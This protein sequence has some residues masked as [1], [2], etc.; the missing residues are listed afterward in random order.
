MAT[1]KID[2][3]RKVY[4]RRGIMHLCAGKGLLRAPDDTRA[5]A[6]GE[7]QLLGTDLDEGGIALVG[8][9]VVDGRLELW[10]AWPEGRE[11]GEEGDGLR[12]LYKR[13]GILHFC[14]RGKLYAR[15]EGSAAHHESRVSVVCT[16][17]S[18]AT[19]VLDASR[20]V[21]VWPR[22]L[23]GEKKSEKIA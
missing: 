11:K 10:S 1:K 12:K 2:R 19:V 20:A 14:H 21:E 17:E 7:V 9:V 18:C 6:G 8:E 3:S 16:D 22:W 23:D 5:S 13:R 4:S 15:A